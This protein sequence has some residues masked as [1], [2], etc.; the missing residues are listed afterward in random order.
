MKSLLIM[1]MGWLL[2]TCALAQVNEQP[3]L[4]SVVSP[5]N[6]VRFVFYQKTS[7]AGKREL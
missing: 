6:N 4:A 7:P 2:S 1:V 5:D 3:G